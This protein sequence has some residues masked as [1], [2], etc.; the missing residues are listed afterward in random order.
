MRYFAL[1]LA[2]VG[3]AASASDNQFDLECQGTGA[4]SV[5]GDKYSE[6]PGFTPEKIRLVLDLARKVWCTSPCRTPGT[7]EVTSARLTLDGGYQGLGEK[8]R[9]LDRMTGEYIEVTSLPAT[10]QEEYLFFRYLCTKKPFSGG[11]PARKF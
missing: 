3:S 8:M 5:S 10:G 9:E 7:V 11:I 6:A 2:M 1:A 4:G